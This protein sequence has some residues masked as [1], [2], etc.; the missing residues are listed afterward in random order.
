[1]DD[2]VLNERLKELRRLKRTADELKQSM[3]AM[4]DAIKA[5]MTARGVD[6]IVTEDH[7]VTWKTVSS[8]RLDTKALKEERPEIYARYA[9]G[10]ETKRLLIS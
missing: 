4:E 7:M 1:M 8:T 3:T 9:H 6:R 2:K 5:E 10:S